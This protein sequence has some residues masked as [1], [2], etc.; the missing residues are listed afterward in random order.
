MALIR[1]AALPRTLKSYSFSEMS[2]DA[3][4]ALNRP[5]EVA[6]LCRA[7][8]EYFREAG[9]AYSEAAMTALAYLREA[10]ERGT[11]TPAAVQPG[12]HLG[13]HRVDAVDHHHAVGLAAE[14]EGSPAAPQR[15]QAR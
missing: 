13:G 14:L 6:E 15:T 7:A 2:L 3:L 12:Q 11:L 5:A 1:A 4:L 8:I 9:L 10:A